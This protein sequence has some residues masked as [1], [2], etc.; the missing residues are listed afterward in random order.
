VTRFDQAGP[1]DAEVLARSGEDPSAFAV[2]YDRYADDVHRFALRRLGRDLADD[3][4]AETFTAAFRDRERFDPARGSARPW[5]F[6]IAANLIGKHRRAEVR[7]LRAV[8]RLHHDPVA[9]SW[10]ESADARVVASSAGPAQASAH[11][12]LSAADR[13]VLLL[14]AW[15]DLTYA[16]VAE[17]L[18]IPVGTVRS[19]LHRARER[20]RR[21]LAHDPSF[22]TSIATTEEPSWTS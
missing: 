11:A 22:T 20:V 2:I 7:G 21:S 19:R 14:V 10:Q 13:H 16:V 4:T 3:L 12:K 5:L 15:A 8:V 17:A 1:S 6:G 18:D 9:D